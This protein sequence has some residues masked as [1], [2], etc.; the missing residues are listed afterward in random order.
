MARK[1]PRKSSKRRMRRNEQQTAKDAT[2]FYA[3]PYQGG[4]GFYF[5]TAEEFE[6][7]LGRF[8]KRGVEEFELQVINGED[9]DTTLAAALLSAGA[10]DQTNIERWYEDIE[11]ELDTYQK[12]ALLYIVAYGEHDLDKALGFIENFSVYEG[13]M[14]EA[15]EE[16]L[17]DQ[18][19]PT[20]LPKEELERYFDYEAYARDLNFNGELHEIELGGETYSLLG[21]F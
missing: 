4:A 11:E 15:A 14:K 21:T 3:Q 2:Q 18:G 9:E 12:A 13:R 6:T 7:V 17:D 1:Q 16:M 10:L 8:R 5:D 19:G 20:T